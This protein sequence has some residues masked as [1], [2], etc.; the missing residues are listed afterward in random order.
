[1]IQAID[2]SEKKV[3]T[4][5][6]PDKHTLSIRT[7][8]E[9]GV[10]MRICQVF[11]RRAF[12]IDSLVVAESRDSNF[13]RM[14]IGVTGAPE[15]LE[16]II[17]QV[18][19]LVYV[20][21]CYEHTSDD[22]VA[23]E[24]VMAKF[25]VK[26]EERTDAINIIEHFDGKTIDLTHTSMIAMIIGESFKIDSALEMLSQ[27]EIIETVRTGQVVMARGERET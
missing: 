26:K 25:I 24:M 10:L 15:G 21:H 1:M 8:N 4:H 13:A 7:K 19:K 9:P 16:Q 27:F 18:N 3:T 12:N 23:K 22:S 14:T 11:A 5:S 17:K 6:R 20:I 2:T